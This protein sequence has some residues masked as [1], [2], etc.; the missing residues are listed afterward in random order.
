MQA[1]TGRAQHPILNRLTLGVG[2][3][4]VLIA[5][6]AVGVTMLEVDLPFTSE[7]QTVS[8]VSSRREVKPVQSLE[9]MQFMEQNLTLPSARLPEPMLSI[10][11][12]QF[13]EENI[14]EY[15]G[16]PTAKT[17]WDYG[18]VEADMQSSSG[19]EVPQD[20][21]AISGANRGD[22]RTTTLEQDGIL[23]LVD[24]HDLGLKADGAVSDAVDASRE[25]RLR[26]LRLYDLDAVGAQDPGLAENDRDFD[27]YRP[28]VTEY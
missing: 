18:D 22:H 19:I 11:R 21:P 10:E 24:E 1:Q 17:A 12:M 15:G 27:G 28:G 8:T 14:W 13:L 16:L 7:S 23:Y 25:A 5:I 20:R 3:A 4:V 6:V 26:N 9:E 2:L